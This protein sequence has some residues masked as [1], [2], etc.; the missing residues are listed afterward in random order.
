M[1]YRVINNWNDLFKKGKPIRFAKMMEQLEGEI[2]KEMSGDAGVAGFAA[3]LGGDIKKKKLTK[4]ADN[5]D[6][7]IGK[8]EFEGKN[9]TVS[10]AY[11]G[12]F[13]GYTIMIQHNS[14]KEF[15]N[16]DDV[17]GKIVNFIDNL[18]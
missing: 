5:E 2:K 9:V 13:K 14:D 10:K 6:D 15:F 18:E 12:E 7:Y 17:I 8:D 11:R 16:N 3:P 4:E 1:E